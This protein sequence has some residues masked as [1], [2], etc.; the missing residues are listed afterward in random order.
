MHNSQLVFNYHNYG[1]G[2]RRDSCANSFGA[3]LVAHKTTAILRGR[4]LPELLPQYNA[5]FPA[6]PGN[7]P[8]S[9]LKNPP[10]GESCESRA[11]CQACKN[12]P[13]A[14]EVDASIASR[15]RGRTQPRRCRLGTTTTLFTP[16]FQQLSKME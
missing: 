10:Q 1:V 3:S 13:L 12:P 14:G 4:L 2:C 11:E 9:V 6:S 7:T 16:I 5:D 15:R 8:L